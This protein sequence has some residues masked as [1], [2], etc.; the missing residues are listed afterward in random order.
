MIKNYHD[1]LK[2]IAGTFVISLNT[3]AEALPV[4]LGEGITIMNVGL[5]PTRLAPIVEALA[6]QQTAEKITEN[7]DM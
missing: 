3:V 4:P 1:S 5:D 2:P 7:Q 6:G